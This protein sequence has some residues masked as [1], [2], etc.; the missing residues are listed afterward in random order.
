MRT[1][2]A[3]VTTAFASAEVAY[4]TLVKVEFPGGT[5]ALNATMYSLVHAGTTY[6][7][8][9]GLGRISATSDRPGEIAGLKLEILKVDALNIALALDEADEVQGSLITLSTAVLDTTTHQI[10]DVLTDWVGYADTMVIGEDGKTCSVGLSA[11]SKAVDLLRG[12]PLVYNNSEQQGLVPGDL[13][14]QYVESQADKPVIW[15]TRE[16][17]YK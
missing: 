13:Y 5:L 9:N 1:V 14:F 15:P 11:E 3:G 16:W 17:F 10:I 8:A 4:A 2:A 6:L 7:A 12:N